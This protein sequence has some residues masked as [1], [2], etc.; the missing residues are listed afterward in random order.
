MISAEGWLP[1]VLVSR[2]G[3]LLVSLAA[4]AEL[5]KGKRLQVA[6]RQVELWAAVAGDKSL[7]WSEHC[8]SLKCVSE[9]FF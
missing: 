9:A 5:K 1:G 4:K 7:I 6:L 3:A 2:G 8:S